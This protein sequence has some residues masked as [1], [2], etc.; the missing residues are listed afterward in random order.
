M[1][2]KVKR[3]FLI[4]M[5]FAVIIGCTGT[6]ALSFKEVYDVKG[7]DVVIAMP[8]HK[9]ARDIFDC[10]ETI[11]LDD[12][13]KEIF[14]E[15]DI[16]LA[17]TP[18]VTHY[19]KYFTS[20]SG[21]LV[22]QRWIDRSNKYMHLV[23]PQF[24][25]QGIPTDLV[26][27]AF[28]ES[29]YNP[30]AQSHA[31]AVGMWQFMSGTGKAY[32]LNINEW[33]DERRDFEKSTAAAARHLYDL[34]K[35]F[36]DWY[37]ALAAYNAGHGRISRATKLHNTN[38]FFEIASGRTL[39]LETKDY[40]PKYLAQLII[41]KNM[42][43]YGFTKPS[44]MPLVFKTV[45]ITKQANL[46][47]LSELLGVDYKELKEL[48]PELLTPMTPPVRSYELRVPLDK[49]PLMAE[50]IQTDANIS[51]YATYNG[52]TGESLAVI[53][54]KHNISTQTLQ[55]VNGMTYDKL[56]T[57]KMLFIPESNVLTSVDLSFAKEIAGLSPKYYTVKKGDNMSQISKKYNMS[58]QSLVKL[59]PAVD[60]KKIYPG[61][62]LVVSYGGFQG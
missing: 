43:E 46:Y 32:G 52:K 2:N 30:L 23:R 45:E 62:V 61:Q 42:T 44:E 35:S 37:L 60:P 50:L 1:Y 18:R 59:N 25:I 27:L 6:S 40:V 36:K 9:I 31:G 24:Q 47:V 17:M 48:N 5:A 56:Y 22:M 8:D 26:V 49:H 53:A 55:T 3:F 16:P 57:N 20:D 54:K 58:L 4:I 14:A 38:D 12:K 29:G 41:Y 7:V 13:L 11:V 33:V 34:N 10:S 51:R 15:F 28:T 19:L 39:Q 21:R